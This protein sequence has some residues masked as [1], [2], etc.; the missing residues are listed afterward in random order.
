MEKIN[1]PVNGETVY[2][3]TKL[4]KELFDVSLELFVHSLSDANG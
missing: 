4:E 1:H 3:I 2:L